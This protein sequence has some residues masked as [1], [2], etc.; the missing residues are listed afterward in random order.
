MKFPQAAREYL[1]DDPQV[2]KLQELVQATEVPCIPVGAGTKKGL[3]PNVQIATD[4]SEDSST[5]DG[6]SVGGHSN[7]QANN[8]FTTVPTSDL[9][10][11]VTYDPSEFL[12]T[13]RAGTKLREL[14]DA[15]AANG[16]Y[17]PFDPLWVSQGATLAGTVASGISGLDRLLY[18][19][20]R[21]FVMEV[22]ILDGLGN[23]VRGGGKVV[24]NAAGFDLP[25]LMVGSYGRLGILLELTLK[26][27]PAPQDYA[28]V[29]VA[30]SSIQQALERMQCVLAKPLPV[31]SAVID[32]DHC[33]S[34]RVAGPTQSLPGV[35]DRVHA[36]I[37]D[38]ERSQTVDDQVL[39]A[40][41]VGWLESSIVCDQL[42]VRIASSPREVA[43]LDQRLRQISNL[44]FLHLAGCSTTWVKLYRCQ[45]AE[46]DL[47]LRRLGVSAVVVATGEPVARPF[48]GDTTWTKTAER[49][50]QAIDPQSKV[51]MAY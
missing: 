45:L 15:L 4:C 5:Q 39:R 14:C 20:V 31:C 12:I 6:N 17:L 35:L 50:R 25:K 19:G 26:V 28:S 7:C 3:I 51:S 18:G 49:V 36:A 1:L 13:A 46:L 38:K 27:F 16:Q 2:K 9:A 48:L 8:R 29:S 42:L 23:V 47:A 37:G 10:G 22:A 11:I 44:Q 24:K 34:L 43:A 21:D 33:L 41:H 40:R 30:C 32:A